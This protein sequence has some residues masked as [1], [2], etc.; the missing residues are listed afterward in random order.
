MI[1]IRLFS[2]KVIITILNVII[3][4]FNGITTNEKVILRFVVNM[5]KNFNSRNMK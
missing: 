5:F 1:I 3:T 4:I 2:F